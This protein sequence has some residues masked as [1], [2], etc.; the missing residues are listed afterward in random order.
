MSSKRIVIIP[1]ANADPDA[2]SSSC[3]L[4][5]IINALNKD[6]DVKIVAPEGIGTECKKIIDICTANNIK[7]T[8]IKKKVDDIFEENISCFLVDVAS[9]EQVKM[10]KNYLVF[11]NNIVT[12]DHH[13]FH[14]YRFESD[15]LNQI[16]QI[17]CPEAL[18]TSEI[19]FEISKYLGIILPRELLEVLLAGVLWDTK[20]FLRSSATTFKYSSEILELGAD[21]QRSQQ[22]I[23]VAKP[24]YAK[25]AKIKCLLRHRGFKITLDSGDVYI[26]LSEV[27]AYESEC[28]STLINIGYDIAFIASEEEELN[29]TRI[30]YRVRDDDR[31]LQSIDIYNNVL[32]N[33]IQKY[34]GSG[35]GHKLAGGA[36]VNI[37]NINLVLKEIVG[38]LNVLSKGRIVELIEQKV[39]GG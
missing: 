9:I 25:I 36:I 14:D 11:C 27:G 21:Y 24:Y 33:V 35:G 3:V 5:Y 29:A 31:L 20:R 6:V 1:H 17:S 32:K 34:G 19:V 15:N 18:S 26:A 16:L 30:I 4:A 8:V 12:I 13:E 23:L 22:L 2:L 39:L 37:M 7:I 28:A 10:L 38:I